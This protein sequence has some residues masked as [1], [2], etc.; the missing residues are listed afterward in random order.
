MLQYPWTGRPIRLEGL[1]NSVAWEKPK[2]S[3]KAVRRAG[4]LLEREPD[5][6]DRELKRVIDVLD[7]PG[8]GEE[9]LADGRAAIARVQAWVQARLVLLQWRSSHGYPLNTF[10]ARLRQRA[11][12]VD[13]GALFAQRLK[14]ESSIVAKL[15]RF[16]NMDLS[17]MQ[18]IGGCRAIV[19][20]IAAVNAIAKDFLNGRARHELEKIDDYIQSPKDDGYRGVHL[21]YRYVGRGFGENFNGLRIEVQLR[22]QVQHAWA[23]AV[24]TVGLFRREAIK[25]GEGDEAWRR[26]FALA[27]E[28][29]AWLEGGMPEGYLHVFAQDLHI[30]LSDLVYD[31]D[32]FGRMQR[33]RDAL[34]LALTGKK[35]RFYLLALDLEREELRVVGYGQNERAQAEKAYADMEKELR[36][37][38]DV[39]LVSVEN[40]MS[41]RKAFPNYFADTTLFLDTL[42]SV[43]GWGGQEQP[44]NWW[45]Q[46]VEIANAPPRDDDN[47]QLELF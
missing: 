37:F 5:D 46:W 41:L 24:E 35:Q 44:P 33:Y 12:L 43:L 38:G 6:L 17:R 29:F 8:F 31:L 9:Q 30:E 3:R 25:A 13:Q 15:R 39:V 1:V 36:G 11:H 28:A 45:E 16:D 34:K 40:I 19:R 4:E 14:R 21:I 32:V 18:D 26:F 2:H 42:R 20:D 27:S 22:T 47:A 7:V 10:Q 23:T